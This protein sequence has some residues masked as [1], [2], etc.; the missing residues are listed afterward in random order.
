LQRKSSGGL[1]VALL[2]DD[3]KE[4]IARARLSFVATVCPDGTPNLSPKSSLAVWDDEHL[5]F[6][7]IRSPQTVANLRQ[8]PSLEVNVVDIFRRRGYRFKGT[9]EIVESG[10][11][12]DRVAN[13]VWQR[14]G[15]QYP[16]HCVVKIKLERAEPVISPAYVFNDPAPAEESVRQR[17]LEK[18]GLRD[19]SD[20]RQPVGASGS[21]EV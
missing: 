7:D 16:V 5:V 17:Y 14:E 20:E 21:S 9:A 4:V 13:T 2:T 15:P 8:N 11:V 19:A 18:Y 10:P 3:M 6:A 1:P 12:Y